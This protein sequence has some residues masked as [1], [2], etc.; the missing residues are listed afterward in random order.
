MT[1]KKYIVVNY[2][3]EQIIIFSPV[4]EHKTV[5]GKMKTISAGFVDFTYDKRGEL[6]A[7]C[8]GQSTTLNM[9]SRYKEDSVLANILLKE[10]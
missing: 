6:K 2:L 7:F 3:G 8:Y 10:N 1:T 9:K 5:A 4:L